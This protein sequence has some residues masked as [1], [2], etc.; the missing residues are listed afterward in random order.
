MPDSP[1]TT[2]IK[3]GQYVKPGSNHLK[4]REDLVGATREELERYG[5][6]S[7]EVTPVNQQT[8]KVDFGDKELTG[9]NL[10]EEVGKEAQ[11]AV[12]GQNPPET[13]IKTAPS[14]EPLGLLEDRKRKQRAGG[15]N[16]VTIPEE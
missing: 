7:P 5:I 8:L 3:L 11:A 4:I 16:S 13:V 12:T 6:E 1:D 2:E 15:G 9:F 14:G 10:V